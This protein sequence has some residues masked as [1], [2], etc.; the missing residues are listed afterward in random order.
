MGSNFTVVK[1][2][3]KN[4]VTLPSDKILWL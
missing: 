3:R 4:I 1:K 2:Q